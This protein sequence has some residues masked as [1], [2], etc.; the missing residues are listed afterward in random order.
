MTR[1]QDR[2]DAERA[3]LWSATWAIGVA[4]GV[5]LG[6][7]L[8]LVGG[9]GAPGTASLDVTHDLVVLP[10]IS[11]FVAFVVLFVGRFLI[12]RLRRHPA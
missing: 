4:I 6:G 2:F 12:A 1:A 3:A 7:W 9:S 5:A 8:T 10:L 11:G